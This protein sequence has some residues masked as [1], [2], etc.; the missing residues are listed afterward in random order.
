MVS[1]YQMRRS[2][3]ATAIL[4]VIFSTQA[5]A[6]SDD[7]MDRL[8]KYTNLLGRGGACGADLDDANTRV[9]KWIDRIAPKGSKDQQLALTIFMQGVMFSAEQ[10]KNG[11]SP[12]SCAQIRRTIST[13]PW[14]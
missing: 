3:M 9:G 5:S 10:Q 13:F 8:T 6:L 11:K 14:P 4:T 7:D 1:N 2:T 12:D